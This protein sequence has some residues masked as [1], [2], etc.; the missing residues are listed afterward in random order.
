MQ[1]IKMVVSDLDGTLLHSDKKVSQYTQDVIAQLQQRGIR[2]AF[3]TARPMWW[4][5]S[6]LLQ[7][8][9]CDGGIYNNG[10]VI[11]AG[12]RLV[13][14]Y[15]VSEP[16]TLIH[17]ILSDRPETEVWAEMAGECYANFSAERIWPGIEYKRTDFSDVPPCPYSYKV[18]LGCDDPKKMK[19]YEKYLSPELY[20]QMS[21]NVIAMIMHRKSN[22]LDAV[23]TLCSHLGL[24]ISQVVAFGDDLN[25][26]SMLT[27]CGAGVAVGN[28]LEPVKA[29]ADSVCGSNDEDGPAR[30]MA[31]N[32]L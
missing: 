15:T 25:D 18:I 14:Q 8:I 9:H 28:A 3:A 23:T 13:A 21:E 22:K 30:W 16:L 4:N 10:A 32:L 24:D 7:G 12:E 1:N 17:T 31:E 6:E 11:K 29:A 20:M 27:G 19:S 2:F 5:I 26:I